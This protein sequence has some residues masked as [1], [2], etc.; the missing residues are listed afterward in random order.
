[1]PCTT[2][3]ERK[4]KEQKADWSSILLTQT[5]LGNLGAAQAHV[6]GLI[7]LLTDTIDL[8]AEQEAGRKDEENQLLNRM[9]MFRMALV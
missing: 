5:F 9:L 2:Q 7:A 8:E 3:K 4:R 1:M 6:H